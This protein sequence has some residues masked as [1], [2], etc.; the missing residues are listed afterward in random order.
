MSLVGGAELPEA[1][2]SCDS[3]ANI[4]ESTEVK[5]EIDLNKIS[6]E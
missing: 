1:N 2:A 5:V 6:R 3:L 4:W